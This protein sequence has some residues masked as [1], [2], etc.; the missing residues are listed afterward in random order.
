MVLLIESLVSRFSIAV[1]HVQRSFHF[2]L[3][4]SQGRNSY[5][6]E[7]GAIRKLVDCSHS[8]N[9]VRV[10]SVCQWDINQLIMHLS[11]DSSNK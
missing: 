7:K 4:D 5:S 9:N 1:N 6:Q 8:N 11:Q 3:G 10:F 2:I